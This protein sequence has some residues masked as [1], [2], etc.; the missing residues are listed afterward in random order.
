MF[1]M[2]K[3]LNQAGLIFL[4]T[5]TL[6]F[7]SFSKTSNTNDNIQELLLNA[8]SFN[9]RFPQEKIYLHL[10]RKTYLADDDIWYKAYLK[11]SPI[12]NCNLYV[13][14]INSSGDIIYKNMTW[15]QNGLAY[16]DFHLADSL[17]SGMYQIR[18][19]TNWMRNFDDVWFFRKN[20]L[21][22][23][24]RSG[25]VH[26][27][28]VQLSK[29]DIDLQFFPE[30]GTFLANQRSKI[31]FKA[32]DENGKG[33]DVDGEIVDN[34]GRKVANFKSTYKGIGSVILEPKQG[35]KYVARV[36]VA[37]QFD[38]KVNLPEPQTYGVGLSID[39]TDTTSIF[40]QVSENKEKTEYK[41]GEKY[42]IIGQAGGAVCF[43]G[44][45]ALSDKI[46]SFKIDKNTLPGGIVKFTLFDQNSIPRCERLVFNN[47]LDTIHVEIT[48]E[49]QVYKPREEVQLNVKA[50]NSDGLPSLTNLSMAVT[51]SEA[52]YGTEEYPDNIFTRF[53]INSELK[54]TIEEPAYYF[55]DD[56]LSTLIALDNLM[57]T[58][59][60]RYFEWKE[61]HEGKE[62]EIKFQP[63][64]CIQVKGRVISILLGKPLEDCDITMISVKSLL[65]IYKTK[66]D[67]IGRFQFSNLYFK[68]TA[69]FSIQARTRKNKKNTYIELDAKNQSPEPGYLPSVYKSYERNEFQ[70]YSWLSELTPE[71]LKRK[72]HLSDTIL[73]GDVNIMARK[74]E[75]DYGL[76]KPY[77][78]ADY[79]IKVSE[80]DDVGSDIMETLEINSAFAR[81]FMNRNP[82]IFVDGIPLRNGISVPPASWIDRVDFVRMAPLQH[83]F[84]PA[85]YY[86]SKRGAPNEIKKQPL[87]TKPVKI[88]GYS[89]FRK[90]YSPKYE[91]DEIPEIKTDFRST[92]YWDPVVRTDS[93]GLAEVTFY[94]SD[95]TGKVNVVIEGINSEG[96]L[97][98]GLA[99]FNVNY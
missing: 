82:E 89:V 49:K 70:T 60:Y 53:L 96:K 81:L 51:K 65:N 76:T 38:L 1:F 30:G 8:N 59:G 25:A 66:S 45:I 3:S 33:I 37:N 5:I 12:K 34:D 18:A 85:V 40:L 28:T 22:I 83:G 77:V 52:D 67:S 41:S 75:I 72:W 94:N 9:T 26:A 87:G 2:K 93:D 56:S 43:M 21:I 97:C 54:G 69:Q 13:E 71:L 74:K 4:I 55:K 64:S 80:L 32:V 79:S 27:D 44:E 58:H 31:A 16:G 35:E 57:L 95:E 86:Y 88:L 61:I 15:S 46:G 19:Y 90:F 92:L 91:S 23:N 63:D 36:N 10:D 68:D 7:L 24:P 47:H 39:G 14:L 99:N 17:S 48:S 29:R 98:R 73:L 50:L 6:C 20:I 42:I 84:G 78:E 62:P 11:N